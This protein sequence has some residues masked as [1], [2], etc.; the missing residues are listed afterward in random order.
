[1]TDFGEQML[2]FDLAFIWKRQK[3]SVVSI[4]IFFTLQGN[5]QINRENE[6]SF[7]QPI[8]I[9]EFQYSLDDESIFTRQNC[10]TEFLDDYLKLASIGQ[11]RI[12]LY[13]F[14]KTIAGQKEIEL[15]WPDKI[16]LPDH[17]LSFFARGDTLIV[18]GS[19]IVLFFDSDLDFIEAKA[20]NPSY[21]NIFFINNNFYGWALESDVYKSNA[22]VISKFTRDFEIVRSFQRSLKNE[23]LHRYVSSKL[24]TTSEERIYFSETGRPFVGVLNFDLDIVDSMI[25]EI[26]NWKIPKKDLTQSDFENLPELFRN[27]EVS[28]IS[29]IECLNNEIIL[30][31][32][33]HSSLTSFEIIIDVNSKIVKE[34]FEINVEDLWYSTS[35]KTEIKDLF[36]WNQLSFSDRTKSGFYLTIDIPI[37]FLGIPFSDFK[38][39]MEFPNR[40][41]KWRGVIF[42]CEVPHEYK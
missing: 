1:M 13:K 28:K 3:K 9:S 8:S 40:K 17:V 12:K 24:V 35:I 38:T 41:D 6:N 20:I 26:P 34:Q 7:F 10:F 42:K 27:G 23:V 19:G 25:L 15:K 2:T 16:K 29:S 37:G 4:F 39:S 36:F 5:C 31:S 21:Q 30:L 33:I 32:G 14:D 18:H 11:N 22:L